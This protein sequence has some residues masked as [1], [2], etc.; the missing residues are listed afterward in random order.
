MSG[1][2]EARMKYGRPTETMS[3]LKISKIGASTFSGFHDASGV[4][5]DVHTKDSAMMMIV[6]TGEDREE[7]KFIVK[8]FK[9]L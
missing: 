7:L 5:G 6:A 9:Q 4:M 8:I 1:P 3:S 2:F